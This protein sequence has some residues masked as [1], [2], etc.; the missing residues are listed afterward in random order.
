MADCSS[1]DEYNSCDCLSEDEH[2][3]EPIV[4]KSRYVKKNKT[5][6]SKYICNNEKIKNYHL[7]RRIDGQHILN[8]K[9][10]VKS[11]GYVLGIITLGKVNRSYYIINGQ[12][13]YAALKEL[14]KE[15]CIIENIPVEVYH[16][17][18]TTELR[19]LYNESNC[20]VKESASV[21]Y[22][23]V[24]DVIENLEARFNNIRASNKNKGN[25]DSRTLRDE[26]EKRFK[27]TFDPNKMF[28]LVCE[29]ND[30]MIRR[31]NDNLRKLTKR[32]KVFNDEYIEKCKAKG[33]ILGIDD[34]FKFLN[35][36]Q[37]DYH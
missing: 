37:K 20:L 33:F 9:K 32:K 11:N 30:E 3:R 4:I 23:L 34:N 2:D 24:A 25:I 16:L 17:S 12:H 31:P 14:L 36:I 8:I 6:D 1:D 26:M 15:G 19:K 13:R 10:G 28:K 7:N 22:E 29:Q 5:W 21:I 18:Y 35:K 27:E